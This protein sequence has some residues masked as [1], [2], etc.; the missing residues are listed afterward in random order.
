[1]FDLN[2]THGKVIAHGATPGSK[3][4]VNDGNVGKKIA[5]PLAMDDLGSEES[6][7]DMSSWQN[8]M[9]LADRVKGGFDDIAGMIPDVPELGNVS[10][11]DPCP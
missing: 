5:N 11:G 2:F 1:M 4:A 10:T 6:D 3:A 7:D 8:P 9:D